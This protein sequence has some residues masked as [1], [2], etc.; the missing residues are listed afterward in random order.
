MDIIN[1]S[2]GGP[3]ADPRTDAL[4]PAVA[5]VVRAGVVPV[6]SAGNDRD[7][8]GLGTAGSPAT[9][10]DAISVG[11][12]RTRTSSRR[13]SSYV[14]GGVDRP[15]PIRSDRQ[16]AARRGR[17]A[18]SGSSTSA[19]SGDERSAGQPLCA[20]RPFRAVLCDGAIALVSRGGCPYAAKE[21]IAGNAGAVGMVIAENRA[22]DPTFALFSGLSGGTISDLDGARLRRRMAGAGGAVQVRFTR[23]DRSRFRRRWAGVPTSFSPAGLTPFGHALKPDVTAPGAQILSSTLPEFAGDQYAV[24]DGTSFSAPHVAGA[25]ALLLQR[26]RTWT[27]QQMKSALMS[28]AGPAFARHDAHPGG[29]GARGGGRARRTS[30]P[31]TGRSSSRTRS[32]SR[33]ATWRR[34]AAAANRT[35]SVTVS[36]AG[37]GAGRGR[38]R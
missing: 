7:F 15:G 18:T 1:F 35:I 33:S 34:R 11:R 29:L 3:Q 12:P 28:T 17:R 2:G 8:F 16:R 21:T 31:P 32:R 37:D 30:A 23:D 27:P 22:G 38:P 13:R 19:R 10:P 24:I 36:D 26:H 9:A 20:T 4:I 25:A 14:T 6:I 5:N